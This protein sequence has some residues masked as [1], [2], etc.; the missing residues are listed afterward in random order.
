[1]FVE[2]F[3][4]QIPSPETT[5]PKSYVEQAIVS[6]TRQAEETRQRIPLLQS[7]LERMKQNETET[8]RQLDALTLA[9]QS[10]DPATPAATPAAS[11]AEKARAP[12]KTHAAGS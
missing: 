6:L 5:D 9:R 12:E 8:K 10:F 4:R 11:R 3:V 2:E 1:M 7:E